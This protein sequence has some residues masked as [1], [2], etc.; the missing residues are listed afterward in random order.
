MMRLSIQGHAPDSQTFRSAVRQRQIRVRYARRAGASP[1]SLQL[2]RLPMS[3]PRGNSIA[4]QDGRRFRTLL[5]RWRSET[6]HLSSL[7]RRVY[8]PSY[9]GII[10]MGVRALPF[11]FSE[12]PKKKDYWFLALEAITG[13]R[14]APPGVDY[15][16][17]TERWLTWGRAH[18][19]TAVAGLD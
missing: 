17:A 11:I 19:Y 14:P 16:V 18:G 4:Y 3:P 10:G 12:L 2:S 8:N 15:D 9:I 6:S 7:E 1:Q 13:A 5:H